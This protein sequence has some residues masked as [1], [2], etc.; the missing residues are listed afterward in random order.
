[1]VKRKVSIRRH[2]VVLFL[3]TVIFLVGLL[4]GVSVVQNRTNYLEDIASKQKIDYESLQL[5]SLYLDTLATNESCY[6]F[7]KILESSLE[8]VAV[9]QDKVNAYTQESKSQDYI[10]IKREYSLAEIR[11]WL[12]NKKI[13]T[14]CPSDTVTILYFYSNEN[15]KNCDSQGVLLTYMKEKFKD[16]LL[17]FSFDANFNDEPMIN[18]LKR[19]NNL[20]E[21]PTLVVMNKKFSGFVEKEE[22]KR[23]ICSYY[24]DA[25]EECKSD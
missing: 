9:A 21:V 23:R 20:T 16:R 6:S 19:E 25:P 8:D 15:C 17:I 22:L 14:T 12:L 24:K 4:L 13:Q 7:N 2:L 10:N 5:Q 1:M 3:T 11:Y 18:I